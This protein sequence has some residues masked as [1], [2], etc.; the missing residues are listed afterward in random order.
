MRYEDIQLE[1]VDFWSIGELTVG[2]SRD[3]VP[4]P[5][6]LEFLRKETEGVPGNKFSMNLSQQEAKKLALYILEHL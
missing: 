6:S 2:W 5:L 3:K 4:F 1:A